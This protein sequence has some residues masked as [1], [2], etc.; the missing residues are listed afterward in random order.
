MEAMLVNPFIEGTLHILSTTAS[1]RARPDPPF[2]KN[3]TQPLG[4]ITGMMEIQGDVSG[5]AALTF[6]RGSILNIVSEMFGEAMTELNEDITDAVGELSNMIAGH[7]NTRMVELDKKAKVRFARI[8]QGAS[9]T[10]DHSAAG[11]PVLVLPFRTTR[12][13]VVLE[14]CI[15]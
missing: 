11:A 2:I 8:F 3:G 14:V 13:K 7:V 4:D 5:S 15:A 9:Q 1:V 6:S 12:G 10:I